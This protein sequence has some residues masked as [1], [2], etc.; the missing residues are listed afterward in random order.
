MRSKKVL[1]LVV[2]KT[3]QKNQKLQRSRH[4]SVNVVNLLSK[5]Q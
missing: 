5:S 3:L 4:R 2:N 1:M